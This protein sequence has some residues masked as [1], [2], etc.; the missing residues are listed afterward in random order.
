MGMLEISENSRERAENYLINFDCNDDKMQDELSDRYGSHYSTGLNL[1][2]YLLRVF[3]FSYIRIEMQG[4]NFDDPNRIFNSVEVS[5]ENATSQKSDLRELIPEF[6]CF[7]EMFFNMNDLNLGEIDDE[8]TKKK[9]PLNDITMPPWS[10]NNAYTFVKYH[11]EML[12]SIEV[13]EKI[14]DWFNIIFGIKQKGN[15]AK[16]IHNLFFAQ[17]YDDF[18]EKHKT[19]PAAEK[20]YQFLVH[21]AL[22][23]DRRHPVLHG[24]RRRALAAAELERPEALYG[25]CRCA[26]SCCALLAGTPHQ[27]LCQVPEGGED[28]CLT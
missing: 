24:G 6:F 26:F 2:Y 16:K 15:L 25:D 14:H 21:A 9:I 20:V 27:F 1:T 19:S 3:P 23:R 28:R 7:P 4:K 17:T 22:Y 8:K 18:D 13:S 5:F 12:E 10:N 11:R